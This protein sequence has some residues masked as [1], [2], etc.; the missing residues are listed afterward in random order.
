MN[1]RNVTIWIAAVVVLVLCEQVRADLVAHWEFEE[2]QGDIAYDSVGSNDGT[3][4]GAQWT[5]GQIGDYALDF[6]G[7]N[8]YVETVGNIPNLPMGDHTI[9]LWAKIDNTSSSSVII[10]AGDAT[11]WWCLS[12][13]SSASLYY[14]HWDDDVIQTVVNSNEPPS[15]GEWTHIVMKRDGNEYSLFIDGFK[16]S[17]TEFVNNNFQGLGNIL[18][19]HGGSY[20]FN[21]TI[22][23]VRIYDRALSGE[24]IRQLYLDGLDADFAAIQ[25]GDAIAEKEEMLEA[26]DQTLEKEWT[27]YDVL[28]QLLKDN[29]KDYDGLKKGDIV[30]AGQKIHSAIQH[31]QQSADALEKSITKLEEA[32]A[33]LYGKPEPE[34]EPDPNLVSYWQFD[35]GLGDIA[36][37]SAGDNDGTIYGAQWT[38]GK[39]GDYALDFDGNNDYVETINNVPSLPMGDHTIT[40]WA[41][42]DN[43]SSSSVIIWAGDAKKWWCLSYASSASLYYAHWD[44]DVI[45]T[46][47]NSNETPSVGKWTHIAMR[48]DGS[49]YSMFIDGFKQSDTEVVNNDFQG[50]ENILIGHGGS[51]YFNGTIDDVRIYNRALS[52]EEIWQLYQDGLN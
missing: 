51:Y 4:Y 40:L 6:D 42:I 34:P 10:W 21:G 44:D 32:L 19:G 5:A 30:T 48:R 39:I 43:I 14:A 16:Q 7:N 22:D 52:A 9:T 15:V 38:A 1:T 47:V 8:D 20:Y 11:K 45:Q 49:E 17:D 36:Y 41:K 24:E 13:A 12:Y 28:E 37:D 18:I 35:E 50:V 46:V 2:G 33:A 26:I 3:I 25:I 29:E 27:V 31:Q 23:D